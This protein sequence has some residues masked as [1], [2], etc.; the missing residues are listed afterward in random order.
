MNVFIVGDTP[1]IEFGVHL[2]NLI[3]GGVLGLR[4]LCVGVAWRMLGGSWVLPGWCW[5]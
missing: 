2:S 5:M 1:S 4:S 3:M